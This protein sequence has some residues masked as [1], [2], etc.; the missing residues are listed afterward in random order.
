MN[1]VVVKLFADIRE[2]KAKMEEAGNATKKFGDITST[3]SGRATKALNAMS[4]AVLAGVGGAMAFAVKSAYEFQ[5]GLEK[6]K[7]AAGLTEKQTQALGK[8]IL[9][10]SNTTGVSAKNITDAFTAVEQAGLRGK[11][12]Y[13]TV[14]AAA[15]ASVI[16][17]EDVAGIAKTIVAV[18]TLQISK[19]QSV[20]DI[21][22]QVVKANQM[23]VGSLD[24]LQTVLRGKVGAS[25]ALFGVNLAQAAAISDITSRA[26]M[27]TARSFVTLTT[28][29]TKLE[30]PTKATGLALKSVGLTAQKIAT[31]AK[32]P[33][34][35]LN[36]LDD[37]HKAAVRTGQSNGA[38]ATELFGS[39]DAGTATVL[40]NN[41][42]QLKDVTAQIGSGS[43]KTLQKGFLEVVT[44]RLA[45][46]I[47]LLETNLQNAFIS[48][49]QF[50]LPAV[51]KV[52]GWASSFFK[53]LKDSPGWR[54]VFGVGALLAVGTAVAV[55]VKNAIQ[56]V[57]GLFGK[58]VEAAN[59]AATNANTAALDANTAAL[60]GKAIGSGLGGAAEGAAEAGAVRGAAARIGMQV[61]TVAISAL[62]LAGLTKTLLAAGGKY[63]IQHEA[64]LNKPWGAAGALPGIKGQRIMQAAAGNNYA[65]ISDAQYAQLIKDVTKAANSGKRMTQ[66]Q[67]FA[68]VQR[69]AIADMKNIPAFQTQF[70]NR[71]STHKVQVRVGAH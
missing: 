9:D 6:L 48:A 18:Q 60:R 52:V 25:L 29:V 12:A 41:L 50:L 19:G 44:T 1:D 49:G 43:G 37:L 36:V 31:D 42:K 28:A 10:V 68:E 53:L 35:F 65:Y 71:S 39:S 33:G 57:K 54:D 32:K 5:D 56:T 23:H 34:G 20:A 58:S 55:K 40:L 21:T 17:G 13:D 62:Y 26:G 14:N 69:M 70:A 3:S 66:A 38:I 46:Q 47:K 64:D 30:H 24:Q 67:I 22:G 2:F 15:K 61:G 4:N 8:Q 27:T 7:N 59:T 45:P 16:T 11:V 51:S 63:N